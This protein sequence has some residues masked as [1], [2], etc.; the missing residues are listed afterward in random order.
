M[1]G[2]VTV[3]AAAFLRDQRVVLRVCSVVGFV[4]FVCLLLGVALYALD[5]LQVRSLASP[6]AK[7]PVTKAALTG[8]PAGLFSAFAFLGLGMIAH[9]AAR[10]ARQQS[11]KTVLPLDAVVQR[12][13]NVSGGVSK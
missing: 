3:I 13:P 4:A 6:A 7:I 1:L 2:F 12:Y 8:L 5:G 11:S 9:R 10:G